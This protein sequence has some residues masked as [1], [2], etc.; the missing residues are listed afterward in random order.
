VKSSVCHSCM[1]AGNIEELFESPEQ[2]RKREAEARAA[3]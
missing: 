3:A 1:A 2:K